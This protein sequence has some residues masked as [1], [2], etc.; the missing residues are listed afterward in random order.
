MTARQ[1][2]TLECLL[3]RDEMDVTERLFRRPAR[4]LRAKAGWG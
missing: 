2:R 3:A 1:H 4:L